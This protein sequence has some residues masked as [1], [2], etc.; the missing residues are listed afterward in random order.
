MN[1][2]NI[3]LLFTFLCKRGTKKSDAGDPVSGGM[4]VRTSTH[5]PAQSSLAIYYHYYY[6]LL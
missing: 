3:I 4:S 6:F 1:A 2:I 5:S